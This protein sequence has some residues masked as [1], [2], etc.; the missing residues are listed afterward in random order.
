MNLISILSVVSPFI[1]GFLGFLFGRKRS[2]AETETIE[3]QN[4]RM[5]IE[6]QREMIDEQRQEIKSLKDVVARHER[7]I[8]DLKNKK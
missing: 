5:I 1:T 4:A 2:K 6:M 8:T 7:E 3:L